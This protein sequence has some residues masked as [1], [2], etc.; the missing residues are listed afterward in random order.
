LSVDLTITGATVN[1]FNDFGC[2][3]SA[4]QA[5]TV[6]SGTIFAGAL[7]VS[8]PGPTTCPQSYSP[9]GAITISGIGTVGHNGTF[10]AGGTTV[11]LFY[12]GTECNQPLCT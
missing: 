5:S 4:G 1:I 10:N 2:S 8:I 12:D 9:N 11:T 3:V 7:E 6:T